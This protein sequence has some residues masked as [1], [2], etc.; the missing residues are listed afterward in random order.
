MSGE[1][2]GPPANGA[3]L[4]K[5]LMVNWAIY[6]PQ[7]Y[8]VTESQTP[9]GTQYM[10]GG[11]FFVPDFNK[12]PY[13]LSLQGDNVFLMDICPS[14]EYRVPKRHFTIVQQLFFPLEHEAQNDFGTLDINILALSFWRLDSAQ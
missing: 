8:R 4:D 12:L 1:F 9:K 5:F 3:S 10:G 2:Q 7:S 11:I 6:W 13:S 14:A